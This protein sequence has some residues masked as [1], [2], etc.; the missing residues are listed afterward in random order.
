MTCSCSDPPSLRRRPVPAGLSRLPRQIGGF[1]EL[2]AAMLAAA[3]TEDPLAGW[4]AREGDDF[5]VLLVELWAVAGDALAFYDEVHAHEAYLRTA[6]R[7]LSVRRL[8]EL[9][10]YVPRPAVG[11]TVTLALGASGTRPITVPAGTSFRSAAADGVPAQVYETGADT[12]ILPGASKLPVERRAVTA[13]SEAFPH[14]TATLMLQARSAAAKVDDVIVVATPTAAAARRVTKVA[15][16]AGADGV[17]RARVTLGGTVNL[18]SAS[19]LAQVEVLRATRVVGLW[20]GPVVSGD[21]VAVA[22]NG[23]RVRLDGVYRDVRVGDRVVLERSGQLRARVVSKVE[24]V[25]SNG[26][27]DGTTTTKVPV[28]R[29]T[30]ATTLNP[31]GAEAWTNAHRAEIAVHLGFVRA[32]RLEAPDAATLAPADPLVV[33]GLDVPP[34]AEA[35]R[36]WL[37]R[38]RYGAAADVTG[39]TDASGLVTPD[40]PRADTLHHPVAAHGALVEATRG[41]TVTGE[42]IGVGDGAIAGQAFALKKKPLTYLAAP[43]SPWPEGLASTLVVHVDGVRWTEVRSFYGHGAAD[44]VYTVRCDA[45]GQATVTFGDGVRGARLRTGATVTASYRHGAGAASPAAGGVS[46]IGRPVA[47]VSSVTNPFA[48]V[49]GADAEGADVLRQAAPRSALRF[50]AVVSLLDYEAEALRVPGVRAAQALWAW[51]ERAQAPRVVVRFVGD[52]GLAPSVAARLSAAGDP[53]TPVSASPATPWP[54]KL[55]VEVVIDPAHLAEDVS[56][57][58]VQALAAP[59]EGL[60]EPEKLPPGQPWLRSRLLGAIHAVA[61]VRAVTTLHLAWERPN[62]TKGAWKGKTW[63]VRPADGAYFDLGTVEVVAA[64]GGS[65]GA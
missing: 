49:G 44:R 59:G 61:G 28:T 53:T 14:G 10:G 5:G 31:K 51:Q 54:A 12:A 23:T 4:R 25:F 19:T 6:R 17:R 33:T 27:L 30:F 45:E 62:G 57:A 8:V 16:E 11:A 2:R 48:P 39:E 60:L 38:D 24:V 1:L 50:G 13:I 29:V 65:D 26:T 47:G 55:R 32:G 15:E 40:R 35:P 43:A 3:G 7:D 56:A 22:S 37:L 21:P 63:G 64:S 58:V 41:E 9:L 18:S 46:Q 20:N 42:R 36:R 34:G 52:A